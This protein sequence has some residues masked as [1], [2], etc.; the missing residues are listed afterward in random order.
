MIRPFDITL[1]TE[2]WHFHIW[3]EQKERV[4]KKKNQ[5]THLIIII[6]IT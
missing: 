3:L 4:L 1:D 5:H 2:S 6:T